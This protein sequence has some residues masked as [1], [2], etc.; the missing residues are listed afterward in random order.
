MNIQSRLLFS[1]TMSTKGATQGQLLL[2]GLIAALYRKLGEES[3]WKGSPLFFL[4][5]IIVID[6]GIYIHPVFIHRAWQSRAQWRILCKDEGRG[7][8]WRMERERMPV[9]SIGKR[10]AWRK[11]QGSSRQ[12]QRTSLAVYVPFFVFSVW[13]HRF[14]QYHLFILHCSHWSFPSYFMFL[15]CPCYHNHVH[16]MWRQ[17][18]RVWVVVRIFLN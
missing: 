9:E 10:K 6:G 12:P 14:C 18:A 17:R 2:E 5:F 7:H 1:C 15:K 16:P 3:V 8:Q 4:N 13:A 11:K